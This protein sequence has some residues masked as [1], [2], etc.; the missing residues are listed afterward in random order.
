MRL[1][2]SKVVGGYSFNTLSDARTNVADFDFNRESQ[3]HQYVN[4]T[5]IS[6]LDYFNYSSEDLPVEGE[7]LSRVFARLR[8]LFS[9]PFNWDG[10]GALP[11]SPRVLRNLY[12]VLRI[13]N[14]TDWQNWLIG[15]DTNGTVGLQSR[16]TDACFSIGSEDFSYY[17]E[18]S[19]NE[20]HA[21][22]VDYSPTE[23]LEMM[24]KIG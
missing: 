2:N 12:K 19:S 5:E 18:I 22:H 14:D 6:S 9:L 17:A 24:R 21:S 23:L 4:E 13:S 3:Y 1:V 20:Y 7:N 11:I 15:P 16:V 8:A 10:E